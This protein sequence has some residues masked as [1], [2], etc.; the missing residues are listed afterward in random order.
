MSNIT[1][2][3][4]FEGGLENDFNAPNGLK[5]EIP[6]GTEL[7]QL[8][9][10]LA[11][12]NLDPSKTNRFVS[13]TGKVLNGILVMINDTDAEIEGLDYKLQPNDHVT[14]ITTLHGG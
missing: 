10:L 6:S 2:N 9:G 4:D 8:P 1:I 13:S 7:H 14:Y 5:F 11:Q 12:K 3:V